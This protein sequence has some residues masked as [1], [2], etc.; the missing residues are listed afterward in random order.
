MMGARE[1]TPMG[2]VER[3]RALVY[4]CE[5]VADREQA[6]RSLWSAVAF[7]RRCGVTWPQLAAAVECSVE[8]VRRHVREVEGRAA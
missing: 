7:A 8:T 4:V 5:A 1:T 2:K 3:E 6:E